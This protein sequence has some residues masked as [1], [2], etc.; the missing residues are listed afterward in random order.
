LTGDPELKISRREDRHPRDAH[1]GWFTGD[2]TID[3]VHDAVAPAAANC[4]ILTFAAGARTAWHTHPLG[5]T[6]IVTSGKCFAQTWGGD[7]VTLNP[8]DVVWFP[9][10]EKHWHGATPHE[11]M[12]HVA[13]QELLDGKSVEWLEHVSDEDYGS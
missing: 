10:G 13:I 11:A 6:L 7:V 8:G 3:P 9:P 12:S 1:P 4:V 5:Q 2:V